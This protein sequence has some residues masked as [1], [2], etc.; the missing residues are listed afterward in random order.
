MKKT[1]MQDY[2][3]RM[4]RVLL[5]IQDN[6]DCDL[7]LDELAGVAHFSP[8]HFHRIFSG[9]LGESVKGH[10]RR[11]RLE[12]AAGRL[13]RERTPVTQIAFEA[14]YE[15]HEAFTRAFKTMHGV[16]PSEFR[17]QKNITLPGKTPSG[18][19]F[20]EGGGLSDFEIAFSGGEKMDVKIKKIEPIRVAFVRHIGPYDQCGSA[21]ESL[22][23]FMGPKG[24]IGP[25]AAFIGVCHDDPEVTPPEKIRYDACITVDDGF[26]PEGDV[27]V[28]ILAGGDYAVTTHFGPYTE[29]NE[30]YAKLYGQWLPN[31]GKS[32]RSS[33]CFEFYLND[34]ESTDPEDLV[35]DI[36]APLESGKGR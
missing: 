12:R 20:Q 29:L 10:I 15:I 2:K 4:L 14:G 28:Q 21:W 33:P 1:T 22:C 23:T 32:L 6:L 31:H 27:G 7:S 26:E 35:T 3:A 16:S 34:P 13:K 5:H 18:V 24:L 8:Y 9:M 11:L 30:T 19:H 17:A 25:G 36:Y